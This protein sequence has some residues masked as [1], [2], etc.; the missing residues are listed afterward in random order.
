[1]QIVGGLQLTAVDSTEYVFNQGWVVGMLLNETTRERLYQLEISPASWG[2]GIA[3]LVQRYY[4][5]DSRPLSRG[6]RKKL[7]HGR[8]LCEGVK[9]GER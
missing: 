2:T 7:V 8:S 9:E 4:S 3:A 1:M 6:C 5:P